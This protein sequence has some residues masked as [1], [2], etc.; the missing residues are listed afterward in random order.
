MLRGLTQETTVK[1]RQHLGPR[2]HF[3]PLF[4][5]A[6][7]RERERERERGDRKREVEGRSWS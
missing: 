3:S 1:A 7:D 5:K 6:K 2:E 4:I